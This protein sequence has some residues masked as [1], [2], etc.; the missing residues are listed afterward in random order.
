LCVAL[1]GIGADELL[2]GYPGFWQVP[3]L[4]RTLSRV[5]A[6]IKHLFNSAP[7]SALLSFAAT[8]RRQPKW[9]GL[10]D[11][12]SSLAQTWFLRRALFLPHELDALIDPDLAREGLVAL[13]LP[14]RLEQTVTDLGF[15]ASTRLKLTA[16]EA[17]WYMRNQLLRDADWAGMAHGVEIR[18]PFVDR[19]LWRDLAPLIAGTDPP[20][21]D[22]LLRVSP[23]GLMGVDPQRP[24]TGFAIPVGPYLSPDQKA[25]GGGGG[26]AWAR[27]LL[28]HF[29]IAVKPFTPDVT[30]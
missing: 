14:E 13:T 11:H 29:G 7:G 12:S 16:L 25:R 28:P 9:R 21:K 19:M 10:F 20:I 3:R 5:P 22:D 2:G 6:C 24:K 23:Q 30:G 8:L 26:R 27:A 17:L 1:S 15:K 4:T 18:V